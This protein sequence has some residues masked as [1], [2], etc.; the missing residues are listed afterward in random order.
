MIASL[1]KSTSACN[2][3][4]TWAIALL[5]ANHLAVA[6]LAQQ[7]AKIENPTGDARARVVASSLD[8]SIWLDRQYDQIYGA[9]KPEIV[10]DATFLRRSHLD[11]VGAIPSVAYAREFMAD[12]NS[13]KRKALID[14]LLEDNKG[15]TRNRDRTA[16]N[17]ARVWRHA[18]IP[19]GNGVNM[20]KQQFEPWLKSQFFQNV[21]YD[22]IAEKIVLAGATANVPPANVT[23]DQAQANQDD[24]D[25][26]AAGF[27]Q[28][29]GAGPAE[30]TTALTRVFLGVR[31]G[32]AQCHDHPFTEWKLK[33]FWGMAAF[34]G[35][36][37]KTE[38]GVRTVSITGER[39]GEF[40]GNF[41]WNGDASIPAGKTPRQVFASWMVSDANPQFAAT[42]VN[43]VW[44]HLCGRGLYANVDDLDQAKPEERLLLD[45]LAGLFRDSKFN[46][47]WLIAGICKS[48][49]YERASSPD[50]AEDTPAEA[51][52][53]DDPSAKVTT[54]P[55]KTLSPEQVFDSLEQALALPVTRADGSPRFNGLR[56][57]LV[58]KWSEA[59]GAKPEQF[60]AGI[61]QALMLMNGKLTS[62]GADLAESRTLRAIVDAPFFGDK[63]KLET[64]FLATLTR[65]PN[66]EELKFL[67]EHLNSQENDEARRN[68]YSEIFWGLLNSPEFVLSQ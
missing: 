63:E 24:P 31:M 7:P 33:D 3:A 25:R 60:R 53:A 6:V 21:S 26:G 50:F 39:G 64:M 46:T 58:Q 16:S 67:L 29:V 14:A 30:S 38:G 18:I 17:L 41:P 28:A 15:P 52:S 32:C 68:S 35:G 34:L 2:W 1:S 65:K 4:F 8:L 20:A 19:Q 55:L 45:T 56:D 59:V 43:R 22:R 11:L 9:Q 37:E 61:P 12:T 5:M 44:Q 57:Q 51:P 40:T 47:R 23:P 49:F 42:A 66:A 10:D 36:N 13:F 62:D 54:R 48:K 27:Y